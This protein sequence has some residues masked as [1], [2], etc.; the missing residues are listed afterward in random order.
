MTEGAVFLSFYFW[1]CV[2]ATI[3]ICYHSDMVTLNYFMCKKKIENGRCS[4]ITGIKST[5]FLILSVISTRKS[6]Y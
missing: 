5:H 6:T 3:Y 4:N 1:V 2:C